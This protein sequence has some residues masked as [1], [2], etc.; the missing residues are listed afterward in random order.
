MTLEPKWRSARS[1]TDQERGLARWLSE[2]CAAG[3]F[4][5]H[6]RSDRTVYCV[7]ETL[8]LI[9]SK[10][11]RRFG[12]HRSPAAPF[13]GHGLPIRQL[14]SYLALWKRYE[15]RTLFVVEEK[16]EAG[17]PAPLDFCQWLDVL[18]GCPSIRWPGRSEMQL[19]FRLE[20]FAQGRGKFPRSAEQ[21]LG[22]PLGQHWVPG[23]LEL[24]GD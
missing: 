8:F 6:F 11:Q 3:T 2:Q 19:I 7:D 14:D 21:S 16:A 12:P 4:R 22:A 23:Q 13:E 15:L 9:E 24:L 18:I 5:A 10:Y 1:E 20:G 17:D